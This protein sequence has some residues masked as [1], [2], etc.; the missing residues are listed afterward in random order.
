M[1]VTRSCNL[2]PRRRSA[3][4][5][6][7]ALEHRLA[8]AAAGG[9]LL[10]GP[11]AQTG[12]APNGPSDVS[13]AWFARIA[14]AP[15]SHTSQADAVA[16]VRQMSWNGGTVSVRPQEWLVQLSPI[17]LRGVPSVA[18]A[19]PL[20]AEGG[21][22]IGLVE[23]LGVAGQVL[24]TTPGMSDAV[25]QARLRTNPAVAYFEPN[26]ILTTQQVPNDP[27]F[28]KLYGLNN[29]GQTGGTSD[30]DIDAPEAWDIT[31][32]SRNV[33]VGVIDTGVD[34]NHP[35]L[36]ANIWTNPGEIPG[37]GHDDDGNGFVDDV[38]G[39]DFVN[40]DGDPMDDNGHGTHVAGTI[41]A[42]G[43]NGRGVTG[44]NWT[45]S[46]MALRILDA[47]GE[48]TV[49]NELRSIRYATM[50]RARGVNIRVTNNSYYGYGYIQSEYDAIRASGDAGILFVAAAGNDGINNDQY[51]AYPAS[52]N[53]DNIIAVAATD[54]NDRLAFFSNYGTTSVDLAAPGVKIYSTLPG[55]QY[56]Y[57]SGTSMATPHVAGAAALTWS[58]NAGATMKEVKDAILG[59]VDRIP[60]LVGKMVTGGRL[61]ARATVGLVS[62]VP[63]N[64]LTAGPQGSTDLGQGPAMA[65]STAGDFVVVWKTDIDANLNGT[66]HARLFDATGAPRGPEFAV[67]PAGCRYADVAMDAN[68][69]W[70]VVWDGPEEDGSSGIFA[71]RYDLTGRARDSA[72]IRVNSYRPGGQGQPSV[73][74]SSAGTF[75]VVWSSYGQDGSDWGVFGQKFAADGSR[76]ESEFAVN[77]T[78]AGMQV[79]T[80][81]AIAP[82][83]R[84]VVTWTSALN[85]N[86]WVEMAN[87]F[88]K[89]GAIGKELQVNQDVRG[90]QRMS[91]KPVSVL[92]DSSFV[93]T[94]SKWGYEDNSWGI[95]ARRIDS[96]CVPIANEF[97][98]DTTT[99]RDQYYSTVAAD[100]NGNF[101]IGWRGQTPA[102]DWDVYARR[103]KASGSPL[104]GEFRVNATTAGDQDLPTATMA[105]NGLLVVGWFGNGPGDVDGVFARRFAPA[106]G[107][108][109]ASYSAG[110]ALGLPLDGA[111]KPA[112]T[113]LTPSTRPVASA[114]VNGVAPTDRVKPEQ[115]SGRIAFGTP[116]FRGGKPLARPITEEV[117]QLL[118]QVFAK[119]NG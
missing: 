62:E 11:V 90:R 24:I 113:S 80:G 89:T 73:G 92:P 116:L 76:V 104:S 5:S 4:L 13:P 44:V 58:A 119:W 88:D 8:P 114:V 81:V 84:F 1:T 16:S 34:Y 109:T 46:I 43:N 3:G 47:T 72:P 30:A 20:L 45:T 17:A 66:F 71:R 26:F 67:T 33:V 100:A 12:S 118:D 74:M 101:T 78:T 10:A 102:G 97:Q 83:G 53:L 19:K 57:E 65:A 93:V 50:M 39:Y 9:N 64:N 41:G 70:V 107:S 49:A 94:W 87:V 6:V 23:G 7:E 99:V 15:D 32:G 40:N 2:T 56:G 98:V 105:G 22:S 25:V 42:V 69:N 117:G 110:P 51:L 36:A 48:G 37:N 63:V 31:T 85:V 18:A 79:A 82:N 103:Y 38:H 77:Q 21:L 14:S 55:G 68:G 60:S 29:T 95:W 112:T 115:A 61:N 86:Q 96:S 35:D 27:E 91:S 52:Y 59:G 111:G 54:Q 75:V 28:S 108:S 106:S